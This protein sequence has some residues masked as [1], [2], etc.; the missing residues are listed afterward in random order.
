M[1]FLLIFFPVKSTITNSLVNPDFSDVFFCVLARDNPPDRL[2]T[3]TRTEAKNLRR[4][5]ARGLAAS[6]NVRI[7][8]HSEQQIAGLGTN[9]DVRRIR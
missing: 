5:D 2:L 8:T 6:S 4:Y 9:R 7:Y 1:K 3:R